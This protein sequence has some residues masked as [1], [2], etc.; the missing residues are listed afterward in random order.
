V[1]TWKPDEQLSAFDSYALYAN[2]LK[3][4]KVV[5]RVVHD[6][7]NAV[8]HAELAVVSAGPKG[9]KL[10]DDDANAVIA[11][12]QLVTFDAANWLRRF[13]TERQLYGLWNTLVEDGLAQDIVHKLD[14]LT[15][16]L[17]S[18]IQIDTKI[19]ADHVARWKKADEKDEKSWT[20]SR[21]ALTGMLKSFVEMYER[22]NVQR[23]VVLNVLIRELRDARAPLTEDFNKLLER[24][25][26]LADLTH[27]IKPVPLAAMGPCGLRFF[28]VADGD[29]A[30]STS[31]DASKLTQPA[32]TFT[33]SGPG[34]ALSPSGPR[35][36]AMS[37]IFELPLKKGD[38]GRKLLRFPE[39]AHYFAWAFG[40]A[41]APQAKLDLDLLMQCGGLVCWNKSGKVL[42]VSALVAGSAL[43]FH[44]ARQLPA[45][46]K[47]AWSAPCKLPHVSKALALA[48]AGPGEVPHA[49]WGALC[50][51]D[52]DLACY[53]AL[54]T[55][56]NV[57]GVG[58]ETFAVVSQAEVLKMGDAAVD[59]L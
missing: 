19:I 42:G 5:S 1:S 43:Q 4:R 3:H 46:Y 18:K 39:D 20:Q 45:T 54:C 35:T 31:F 28:K 29:I 44:V 17:H 14:A 37:G 51:R 32:Q 12:I 16:E 36:G 9:A 6:M 41:D 7:S 55:A 24:A 57:S 23:R 25:G 2:A 26:A 13:S 38:P 10:A 56:D 27:G 11:R 59:K 21:D 48:F 40:S 53:F 52:G 15:S 30:L 47:A 22:Q 58:H 34:S 33:V 49:P 8:Q 50:V